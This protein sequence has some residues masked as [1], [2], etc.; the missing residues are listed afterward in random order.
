MTDDCSL[1]TE[2]VL[3]WEDLIATTDSELERLGWTTE[4]AV[5]YLK[6][7][8]GYSSRQLLS[9]EQILDFIRALQAMP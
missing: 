3:E 8:Y 2:P 9:D 6:E 7:T 4:Q 5:D 1:M